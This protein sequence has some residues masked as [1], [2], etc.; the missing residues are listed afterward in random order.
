MPFET[1][2]KERFSAFQKRI[3]PDTLPKTFRE[4]INAARYLGFQYIWIDSLC[5]LQDDPDDWTAESS[6]MSSVYGGSSLNL[7][8]SDAPNGAAGC[9]F[10][11]G[12]LWR[13]QVRVNAHHKEELYDCVPENIRS[14]LWNTQLA[15]RCWV[16]QERIL[17]HRTLHFTRTQLFWECH[18]KDICETFPEELPPEFSLNFHIT[19]RPLT[20]KNWHRIVSAYSSAK[21]TYSKDK[22]IAISGIARLIQLRT[23]DQYIAGMWRK[24][25]EIQLCWSVYGSG[26][27]RI[28]PYTAP[29]WSW[30]SIDTNGGGI[31]FCHD[32]PYLAV[33]LCAQVQEISI[34]HATTDQFG[35]TLSANLRLSCRH[36]IHARF[37]YGED[38]NSVLVAGQAITVYAQFDCFDLFEGMSVDMYVVPVMYNSWGRLC[39]LTVEPTSQRTGQYYRVGQFGFLSED[40]T[41][42][43]DDAVKIAD[44]QIEDS[45]YIEMLVDAEGLR[46][47]VIDII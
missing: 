41:L 17:A 26:H 33:T 10:N 34:T 12:N 27:Q 14:S 35:E 39:G 16:V 6:L 23:K 30:A 11:R 32:E 24:D 19:K 20:E 29:S 1:L 45:E 4:A 36:L 9:F 44:S 22:L 28:L 3:A 25:I 21:L 31:S 8:A 38:G 18:E 5:I 42:K 15:K 46:H 47:Y 2:T 13:C 37:E 40:D 43:F 7:A